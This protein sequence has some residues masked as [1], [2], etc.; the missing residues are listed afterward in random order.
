MQ[1]GLQ[2]DLMG[3]DPALAAIVSSG[4]QEQVARDEGPSSKT[5]CRDTAWDLETKSVA[6]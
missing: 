5:D 1:D 3:Y 6:D 2:P 4:Q